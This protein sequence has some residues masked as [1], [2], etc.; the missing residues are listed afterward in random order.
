M[1][2][3]ELPTKC[4]QKL[5]E[6]CY[7]ALLIFA[8]QVT[9]IQASWQRTSDWREWFSISENYVIQKGKRKHL[10]LQIHPV[11]K[12]LFDFTHFF[13]W[14]QKY[15]LKNCHLQRI[16]TSPSPWSSLLIH[17]HPSST[18]QKVFCWLALPYQG[19][20]GPVDVLLQHT[21]HKHVHAKK[22]R[23]GFETSVHK[24]TFQRHRL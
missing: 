9:F 20:P 23:L 21:S 14:L 5:T 7:K 10:E 12:L 13:P 11:A 17:F 16:A 6:S 2:G 19:Y 15:L 4:L 3:Q 8:N 22:P 1:L 18:S 24:V